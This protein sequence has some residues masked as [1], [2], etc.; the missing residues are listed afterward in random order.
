[1]KPITTTLFCL[2][3]Y[4]SSFAQHFKPVDEGSEVKF[5]IKNFGVNISGLFTGLKGDIVF[6]PDSLHAASFDVTVDAK[7]INTG[8]DQRDAHLRKEEFF[9]A[10]KYPELHFVSTKITASTNKSYLFI[11]G[12]LTIK[13]VTKDVSFPFKAV[14]SGNDY[15]LTGEFS[16]NRRDYNVGGGSITMSDNLKVFLKVI[17]QKQPE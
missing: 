4:A 15:V 12:K 8:I 1:M 14:P 5:K 2:L 17:A 6:N 9:D 3:L 13:N 16:I 7:S 10:E 11:F